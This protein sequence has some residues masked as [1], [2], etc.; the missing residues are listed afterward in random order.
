MSEIYHQYMRGEP[1]PSTKLCSENGLQLYGEIIHKEWRI[2]EATQQPDFFGEVYIQKV[3]PI[4]TRP[5][6][7]RIQRPT[8]EEERA[9]R[10]I[11]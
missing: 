2:N 6:V 9:G 5:K 7:L 1:I 8:L 4:E 10:R 11:I 3:H